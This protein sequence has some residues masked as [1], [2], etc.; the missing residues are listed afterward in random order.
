MI[1]FA[2]R[3]AVLLLIG[4]AAPERTYRIPTD[5]VPFR[6]PDESTRLFW[7]LRGEAPDP[8][9]LSVARDS[10]LYPGIPDTVIDLQCR[11]NGDLSI[12]SSSVSA[13]SIFLAAQQGPRLSVSGSGVVLRGPD[14]W[15]SA[16]HISYLEDLRLSP[17]AV[18]LRSL[19]SGELCLVET[20]PD[21]SEGR[22]CYPAPP[23][24]IAAKF[25]STCGA[26]LSG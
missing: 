8:K 17:K 6:V 19:L 22:W 24:V 18:Q 10:G 9:I 11:P 20:W 25:L 1:R 14:Q 12:G 21:G 2:I 13:P 3:M 7:D 16:G 15:R 5:A 4:C 26:G 23:P